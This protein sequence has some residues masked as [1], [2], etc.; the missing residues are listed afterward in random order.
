MGGLLLLLLVGG[1]FVFWFYR[2]HVA[3]C[4]KQNLIVA[5]QEEIASEFPE[6]ATSVS[7][8]C[9]AKIVSKLS[10]QNGPLYRAVEINGRLLK[11]NDIRELMK[12]GNFEEMTFQ[13]VTSSVSPRTKEL[14]SEFMGTVFKTVVSFREEL[15]DSL[16]KHVEGLPLPAQ[17]ERIWNVLS[18]VTARSTS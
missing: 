5:V 7:Q 3:R 16:K 11:Q 6:Y 12:T 4:H 2:S 13:E 18:R 10:D 1:G 8:G 15:P 14:N 17:L 9:A